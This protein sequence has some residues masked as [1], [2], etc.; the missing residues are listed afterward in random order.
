MTDP[1]IGL[2]LVPD[3][4][5]RKKVVITPEEFDQLVNAIPEPYSTMLYV[6]GWTG[7]RVSELLGLKWQCLQKDSIT[8][9][10]RYCRGD[11]DVPKT[12]A[13]AATIATPRK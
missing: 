11:W 10:E 13:S 6:A 3:K 12:K 4:K 9:S 1:T 7:L 2:Q 8:I 5:A